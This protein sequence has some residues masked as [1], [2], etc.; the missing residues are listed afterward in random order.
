MQLQ[1]GVLVLLKAVYVLGHEPRFSRAV[2]LGFI[3]LLDSQAILLSA[4]KEFMFKA[5]KGVFGL[6]KA[7]AF[8][9]SLDYT[10]F[11]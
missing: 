2:F 10:I 7:Q 8:L 3:K 6:C 11:G 4:N 5:V 1:F 9:L